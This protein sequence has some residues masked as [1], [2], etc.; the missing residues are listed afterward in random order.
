M[1]ES[2]ARAGARGVPPTAA[3]ERRAHV[4]HP[5]A[6]LSSCVTSLAGEEAVW[7]ALIRDV[8]PR[9]LGLVLPR[10]FEPGSVLFV[11]PFGLTRHSTRLL[12]VKVVQATA[13]GVGGW[14]IG[15]EFVK[16]LGEDEVRELQ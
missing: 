15:C 16:E 10:R 12:P 1:P 9:G 14:L 6:L 11:E 7:T 8:S 5:S 2:T 3:G 13:Q 4:R